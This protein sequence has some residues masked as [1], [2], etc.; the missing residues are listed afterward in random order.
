MIIT[1]GIIVTNNLKTKFNHPNTIR[2]TTGAI[3]DSI[4]LCI[5]YVLSMRNSKNIQRH[6]AYL[7]EA[8]L[9]VFNPKLAF[10]ITEHQSGISRSNN[11]SNPISYSFNNGFLR[12]IQNGQTITQKSLSNHCR[13]LDFGKSC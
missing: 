3:L 8:Y 12:K 11:D 1:I 4:S 2:A 10:Y 13:N 7:V 6:V 5:L 9:V